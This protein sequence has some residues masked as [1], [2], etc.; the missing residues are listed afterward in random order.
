ME[1]EGILISKEESGFQA[2]SRDCE[3][4]YLRDWILRGESLEDIFLDFMRREPL[5]GSLHF[6]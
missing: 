4:S 5:F 3:H 2:G 6:V 1:K